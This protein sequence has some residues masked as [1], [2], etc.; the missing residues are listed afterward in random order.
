[1]KRKKLLYNGSIS[2]YLSLSSVLVISF[3]FSLLEAARYYEIRNQ[4]NQNAVVS[5][6]SLMGEYNRFL[7]EKYH[8]LL[9]DG[10]GPD[11]DFNIS[12][13]EYRL[14][15][16]AKDNAS[17]TEQQRFK[18][19]VNFFRYEIRNVKMNRYLLATDYNGNTIRRQI[20]D[21]MKKEAAATA[22]SDYL[23]IKQESELMENEKDNIL[24]QKLEAEDA[25]R[26][27][28]EQKQEHRRQEDFPLPKDDNIIK[29]PIDV[30]RKLQKESFLNLFLP[31]DFQVS[32]RAI[33]TAETCSNRVHMV[34]TWGEAQKTNGI[35]RIM[36]HL[37]LK[38]YFTDAADKTDQRE[39]VNAL[40]YELE[41]ML[42]GK[43][44]D[45]ANLESVIKQLVLIREAGNFLT[46]MNDPQKKSA[47][48]AVAT[49]LAG[50][51]GLAPLIKA[52]QIGVLL[53]WAFIESIS[54]I[55]ELFSG[56]RIPLIKEASQWRSDIGNPDLYKKYGEK[57]SES[58]QGLLY[59][60]YIQIL[61]FA[62][63]EIHT[64]YRCMDIIEQ[65]ARFGGHKKTLLMD[66]M[67]QAMDV[68]LL[69]EAKELFWNFIF[70]KKGKLN[71]HTISIQKKENY[72]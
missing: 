7:W 45:K 19:Y 58:E 35:D 47:A 20:S 28:E 71:N 66:H 3:F 50:F 51:T 22:V 44:S 49:G 56:R 34:G 18:A 43:N 42:S 1:M 30:V 64:T 13:A 16:N 36:F 63:N 9:L 57:E 23:R 62:Q 59:E 39:D 26:K 2:I 61:L 60:D 4:S 10:S 48:L 70:I 68:Q 12:D 24:N 11:G 8:L 37:Y 27:A 41:Y 54:D 21:F 15:K 40:H 72:L 25:L 46:L 69:Y 33:E 38:G 52:V 29:N 6:H 17:P 55:R 14:L 32:D 67:I 31:D 53:A 65:N 5:I